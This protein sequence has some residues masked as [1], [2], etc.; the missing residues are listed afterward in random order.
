MLDDTVTYLLPTDIPPSTA[1]AAA[2]TTAY[3]MEIEHLTTKE[4]E[5]CT[6]SDS[7]CTYIKRGKYCLLSANVNTILDQV[8]VSTQFKHR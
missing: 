6:D 3:D 5:G 4:A 2:T 7:H 8:D 1:A